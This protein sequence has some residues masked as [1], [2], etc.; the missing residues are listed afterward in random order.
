[1]LQMFLFYFKIIPVMQ[2]WIF[3]I[4]TPVVSVIW[5]FRNYSN[6]LICCSRKFLIITNFENSCA[7]S[8]FCGN[9]DFNEQNVQKN[10]IYLK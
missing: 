5:S 6:M 1:M 4:I 2:S 9:C 3:S 8:Y 7:A 10:R